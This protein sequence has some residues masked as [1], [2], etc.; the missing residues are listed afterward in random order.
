MR[1]KIACDT[2]DPEV[3]GEGEDVDVEDVDDGHDE[4]VL[5]GAVSNA[6]EEESLKDCGVL[7]AST[8]AL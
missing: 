7:T 4:I 8:M 6:L 1:A 3:R 5:V 2:C